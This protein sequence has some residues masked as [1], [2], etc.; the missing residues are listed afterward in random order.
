MADQSVLI[1]I[2]I[3]WG[4]GKI[5]VLSGGMLVVHLAAQEKHPSQHPV[6]QYNLVKWKDLSREYRLIYWDL[7]LRQN[8]ETS[9]FK[10]L[11]T[12]LQS[13]GRHTH[14]QIWKP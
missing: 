5:H 1:D 13:G 6:Q 7:C 10:Y 12:I 11:E 14:C 9:L 8:K 2:S 3:G 4:R